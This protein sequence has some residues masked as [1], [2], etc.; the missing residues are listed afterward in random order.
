MLGE[1]STNRKI[2][3][4]RAMM[5]GTLFLTVWYTF[6]IWVFQGVSSTGHIENSGTDVLAFSGQLLV[7]GFWG[8]ALPLAV[9]VAVIG[10]CQIQMTEP[11][12]VLYALARD[13]LIP[14][15]F[16]LINKAAPDTVGRASHSRLDSP[17]PADSVPRERVSESRH[18]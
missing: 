6:L 8:R 12:R 3:P 16:G 18:W 11:S 2:N 4:G 1:E 7:P 15:V 10:T 9:L 17:D 13:K 5:M 14:K